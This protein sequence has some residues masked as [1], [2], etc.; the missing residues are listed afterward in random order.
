MDQDNYGGVQAK[1]DQMYDDP[2]VDMPNWYMISYVSHGNLAQDQANKR[3]STRDDDDDSC[4]L[5]ITAAGGE[6]FQSSMTGYLREQ[7]KYHFKEN[8]FG[9]VTNLQKRGKGKSDAVELIKHVAVELFVVTPWLLVVDLVFDQGDYACA[10]LDRNDAWISRIETRY[11]FLPFSFS[12]LVELE[13]HAVTL[14]K[15]IRKFSMAQEIGA[16][17]AVHIFNRISFAIAKGVGAQIV[18]R[19]PSNFCK[20]YEFIIK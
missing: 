13:A 3:T 6:I 18:S 5:S 16:R 19:L 1:S 10:C 7:I 8:L 17:A 12:S 15:R 14:L 11:E 2:Q 4:T 20:S 9:I